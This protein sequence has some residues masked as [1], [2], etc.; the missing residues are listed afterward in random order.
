MTRSSRSAWARAAISGHDAA[1]SGVQRVLAGDLGGEDRADRQA[2]AGANQRGGGV[3][4]AALD[5]EDEAVAA[6]SRALADCAGRG[7]AGNTAPG[8]A[9]RRPARGAPWPRPRTLLLTRPEAQ[10]EAFAAALEARLPGRFR[11]VVAPLIEIAPVPGALDLAGVQGLPSPRR[12]AVAAVRGAQARATG[13]PAWCVGADDR[14]GGAG[15]GVRGASRPT[16]TSRRWRALVAAAHRP[17]AG[18][19]L[20][21]R[22][23]H[24]AGDLAALLA[25]AGVPARGAEI[26]DQPARPLPAAARALLAAGGVELLAFF[27]PR[28]ARDSSPRR[29]GARAGRSARRRRSRSAPRP[30][31]ARRARARP[32]VVAAAP[33]REGML[34]ALAGALSAA[35]IGLFPQM[36]LA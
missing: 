14:R 6:A 8:R 23:R 31:R 33:D 18:D 7:P 35:A 36:R 2:G 3:V 29:P 28:A 32:A 26:Y 25:A 30:T 10:A 1:V 9:Q 34:A 11:A 12:T 4:A 22:G 15:G 20:H 24:A 19:V 16:A 27:S 5:P 21:V 17:G 13:L